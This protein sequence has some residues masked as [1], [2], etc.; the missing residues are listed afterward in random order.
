MA[1]SLYICSQSGL[2]FSLI[3]PIYRHRLS[4]DKLETGAKQLWVIINRDYC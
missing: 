1:V 4:F 2:A 3:P